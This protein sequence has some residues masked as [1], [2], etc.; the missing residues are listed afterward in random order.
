[1]PDDRELNQSHPVQDEV[2]CPLGFTGKSKRSDPALAE[3][4]HAN[5]HS[6]TCDRFRRFERHTYEEEH[7]CISPV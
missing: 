6:S 4:G 1:M 5:Y 3:Y 7:Q 2:R